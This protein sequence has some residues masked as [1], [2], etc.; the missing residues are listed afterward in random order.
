MKILV[1]MKPVADPDNANK[2]KIS[3]DGAHV[4]AEGLESKPN[5][6]D[7]YAVE[8]AIRI[9]EDG[10]GSGK[11]RGEVVVVTIAGD[12]ALR[13]GDVEAGGRE[14]LHLAL[15]RRNARVRVRP[16]SGCGVAS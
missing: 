7:E 16:R 15:A 9:L 14:A 11:L 3:E 5:P 2:V 6:F 4:T 8:T 12:G 1:P 13:A 10:V